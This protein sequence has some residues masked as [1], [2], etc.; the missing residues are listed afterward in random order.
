MEGDI[1]VKDDTIIVT[2]YRDHEDLNLKSNFENMPRR[3]QSEGV[4]PRI[5]WLFDYKLDFR[6]K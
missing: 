3:L 6:F 2:Y 5:P 4:D 1:R